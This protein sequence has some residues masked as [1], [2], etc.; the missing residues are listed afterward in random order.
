[1]GSARVEFRNTL[2]PNLAGASDEDGYD[3]ETDGLRDSMT[4]P[5][6]S[7]P[8]EG[9]KAMEIGDLARYKAAVEAGQQMGW[10][11][12]FPYLLSRNRAGRSAVLLGE[13][14]GSICVFLW[15][16]R[17]SV[18]HLDVYLAP[19]P[20]SVP[21]LRRCIERA[22]DFNGDRSARVMRID[23]KDVGAVAAANLN[24]K[25]QKMQYVFAPSVYKD[26]GGSKYKTVRRNVALVEQLPDVEVMQYS[27]AHS[28]ACHALLR[29]WRDAHRD[30][31]GTAGGVGTSRRAIDLAGT[32]PD[33]DLRG[34]VVFLDGRLSAFA[35]GGEIRPGL[36]CSF[37]RKCD[38]AVRGLS[39]FHLRS[40]LQSLHE[41]ALVNDGS[42]TGR[43]GLHQLKES[44]RPV[45]MHAEYRGRQRDA[46]T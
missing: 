32:L 18:P 5:T 29:E 6:L 24:V 2:R 30:A 44:F 7:G 13:D 34:E 16:L 38:T 27:A 42:D 9:L 20:M 12:Y 26:L 11:Y 8:L 45:E 19:T 37:E 23:D 10:G 25:Q 36:A 43:A 31:H 46:E 21:V 4:E 14:E 1:M 39:Y 15:Q 17:D 41:F 40:F 33:I 35:F 3:E 22:N 28:E